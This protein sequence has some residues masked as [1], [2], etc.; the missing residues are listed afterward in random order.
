M[1]LAERDTF[2]TEVVE[3]E[4]KKTIAIL[5]LSL[6]AAGLSGAIPAFAL[7][8]LRGAGIEEMSAKPARKKLDVVQGGIERSYEKQPPMIPHG[9]EKYELNLRTNGCL[10]CHS[11]TTAEKENTKPTPASH[12]LDRDGNKLQKVSARR[13]FCNQCHAVQMKGEPLVENTFEG[14]Q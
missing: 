9:I 7:D 2:E 10:K 8:S 6:T 4:M 3:R 5:T 13:Y 12:F 1:V 11:E 14:L